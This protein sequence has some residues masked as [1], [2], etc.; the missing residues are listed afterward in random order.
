MTRRPASPA[1]PTI[2]VPLALFEALVAI[3][4]RTFTK[5]GHPAQTV[6]H[7][8]MGLCSWRRCSSICRDRRET[9]HAAYAALVRAG[10]MEPIG[11]PVAVE[12]PVQQVS[13]FESE[14]AG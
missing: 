13:L 3:T 11:E 6:T 8:S 7:E 9:L 10:V 5:Q 4:A 14:V 12:A 1:R 2:T